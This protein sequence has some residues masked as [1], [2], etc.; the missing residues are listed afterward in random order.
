MFLL[1][2][3]P[4]K[5]RVVYLPQ[6]S[7]LVI[8]NREVIAMHVCSC[9][10]NENICHLAFFSFLNC[11]FTCATQS[12]KYIIC[13]ICHCAVILHT[14]SL[15]GHILSSSY[16]TI[17]PFHFKPPFTI[18]KQDFGSFESSLQ[19]FVCQTT[20]D[21]FTEGYPYP[22]QMYHKNI[23]V[24]II[25]TRTSQLIF[26][27]LLFYC[28]FI[29]LLLFLRNPCIGQIYTNLGYKITSRQ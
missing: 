2:K 8:K 21:L 16:L 5:C 14:N 6:F 3:S 19:C 12:W 15:H 1:I 24:L 17:E 27:L 9:N 28:F 10:Q 7:F 26:F 20:A 25:I 18:V 23:A 22:M 13:H 11:I 29:S 4:I